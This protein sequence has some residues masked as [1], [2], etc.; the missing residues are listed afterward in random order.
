MKEEEEGEEEE[1]EEEEDDDDED[2][3]CKRP[4]V[5]H[6]FHHLHELN[7]NKL[8]PY[9]HKRYYFINQY[10]N[11]TSTFCRRSIHNS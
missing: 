9:S 5:T 1:E 2:D 10:K 7:N 3:L 11:K 4:F 8:E 6:T